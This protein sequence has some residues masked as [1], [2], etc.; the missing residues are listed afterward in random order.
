[1]RTV[2]LREADV[3]YLVPILA[4]RWAR[5]ATS[6]ALS[7]VR[8][9]NPFFWQDRQ[10]LIRA[11]DAGKV[12]LARILTELVGELPLVDRA[13]MVRPYRPHPS[14]ERRDKAFIGKEQ[15]SRPGQKA[16]IERLVADIVGRL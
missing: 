5:C 8:V 6:S 15:R 9:D 11:N 2:T 3:R 10:A 1:M 16:E 13:A 12:A 14:Y 7:D 4:R